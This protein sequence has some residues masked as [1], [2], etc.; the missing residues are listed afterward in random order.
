MATMR[1]LV[2]LGPRRAVI[3]DVPVPEPGRGQVRIDIHRAGICGTDLELFSGE[4]AYLA[5]GR[6]SYPL[7]P[8]HE[9]CGRV[10]SIGQGVA[11]D[12]LGAQV[13]GD[14]MLNCGACDRCRRGLGHVCRDLVEVG[15]SLG[16]AGALA[17]KLVVPADSLHRLPDTI[18]DT[19]GAL[20]EP[21]GNAWR[22][23]AASL[24]IGGSRVLVWGAGTIGL[25]AAAFVHSEGAEV[26]LVARDRARG[27][28]ARSL[29]V[30]A[31][32][33]GEPPGDLAFHS[34]I[35]ATDDPDVPARIL[36]RVEPAGR[37]VYIGVAG[38]ASSIDTRRLVLKDVT[39]VGILSGS[40]GLEPA[41]RAYADNTVDPR[42]LVGATLSLERGPDVLAGWHPAGSGPKIHIDPRL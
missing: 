9:W 11:P 12:W 30:D 8:G 13:M 32:W 4:M 15:I 16:F 39:A 10:E 33:A 3:E 20:V 34:V 22:A 6:A 41:I 38:R 17:E 14:T 28:L 37:V 42:P 18:D 31:L 5:S 27:D 24:L 26:H 7:R 25:L 2:I 19:T 23:A 1:A 36:D 40:P 35:D 29:G 21:G